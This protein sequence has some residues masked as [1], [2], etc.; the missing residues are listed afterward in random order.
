MRYC[1]KLASYYSRFIERFGKITAPLTKMLENNCPFVWEDDAKNAFAEL[2]TRLAN[3]PII[4]YVN[5]N[6]PF[7]VDFDASEKGIGA[8]LFQL[9]KY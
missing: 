7:L 1:L 2:C 5:F 3:A 8:V 6:L 9:G 4:I